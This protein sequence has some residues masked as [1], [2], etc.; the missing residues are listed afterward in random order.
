MLRLWRFQ[1][2]LGLGNL[3]PAAFTRNIDPATEAMSKSEGVGCL[4]ISWTK[5]L[6]IGYPIGMGNHGLMMVYE[7]LR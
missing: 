1:N 7:C 2:S 5:T 4:A 3:F 6:N